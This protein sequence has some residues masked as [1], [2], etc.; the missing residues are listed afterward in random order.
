M[1][2]FHHRSKKSSLLQLLPIFSNLMIL[3]RLHSHHPDHSVNQAQVIKRFRVKLG[4]F[5]T[6][7]KKK[8]LYKIGF[9]SLSKPLVILKNMDL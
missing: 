3:F 9:I 7:R 2:Y 6:Q 5:S 1:E 4:C 8:R